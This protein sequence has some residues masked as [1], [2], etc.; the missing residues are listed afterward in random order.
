MADEP[1]GLAS[2]LDEYRKV[3]LQTLREVGVVEALP[4]NILVTP[5]VSK[6]RQIFYVSWGPCRTEVV[7]VLSQKA[8]PYFTYRIKMK[9]KTPWD[10]LSFTPT[11]EVQEWARFLLSVADATDRIRATV[12]ALD[13]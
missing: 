4:P 11:S 6:A 1:R 2:V 10:G 7:L 12:D 13:A 8:G 3:V 9:V 5:E